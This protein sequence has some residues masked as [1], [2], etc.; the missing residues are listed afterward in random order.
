MKY[1]HLSVAIPMMDERENVP[2]L[3]KLLGEQ[4]YK[5]FSIYVC[6]NQPDSWYDDGDESHLRICGENAQSIEMLNGSQLPVHVIDCSSRGKGWQPRKQGVGWARKLLFETILND[7]GP[8]EIIVSLDAD[9]SFSVNYLQSVLNTFN[10]NP[11]VDA[12]AVPYYHPLSGIDDFDRSL[13]RYE[14]YMRHYLIEMLEINNPYAFCALGSAIAFTARA[15]KRVGGISPLQGGEDFY[16]MQKFAKKGSF[17]NTMMSQGCWLDVVNNDY[18]FSGMVFPQGRPS[19]RV[20]FGTGPAVAL[21]IAELNAKYP[22]YAH[23]AFEDI[24]RTYDCF[25][26]IY[27]SDVPTPMSSFLEKQLSVDSLWQPL[28]D[29]YRDAARFCKACVERVDGLRI[30]QYLKS[31]NHLYPIPYADISF[32]HD[33]VSK[34]N[35][36]RNEL[37]IRE[38]QLR[39]K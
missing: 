15:Y 26:D 9:T 2:H 22:F 35:A 21:S 18:S 28:R 32:E 6:V 1:T 17:T 25:H 8:D 19:S 7:F 37:F 5:N 20:P 12:I 11:A 27:S 30:L 31:V 23:G 38:M 24:K 39:E 16:L 10:Q 34:L 36:F 3:L 33:D 29:N 13:L 14:C 4:T